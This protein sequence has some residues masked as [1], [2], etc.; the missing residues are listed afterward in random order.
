MQII[1][2]LF[3]SQTKTVRKKLSSADECHLQTH[4]CRGR[5]SLVI[6]DLIRTLSFI[7][8][9]SRQGFMCFFFSPRKEKGTKK[10]KLATFQKLPKD[11]FL[12]SISR[13]PRNCHRKLDTIFTIPLGYH[14]GFVLTVCV[15]KYSHPN[16]DNFLFQHNQTLCVDGFFRLC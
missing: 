6:A 7:H 9:L 14:F 2:A 10:K 3:S 1:R 4:I 15:L 5:L 16:F 13:I 8:K 11:S 12:V